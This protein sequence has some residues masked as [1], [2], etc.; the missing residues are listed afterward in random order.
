[1]GDSNYTILLVEDDENDAMLVR[2][3]F[4]KNNI[5]NP[6]QWAK[7]GLEAVAYLNGNGV[8]ADRQAYPFPDVLIVDLKMPRMNGLELLAWIRDH[9][10]YRVI[11]TIIITSSR[12]DVDIEK[13]Y[14]LGANTYMIKPPALDEL[15]K[16]VKV[17]HEYWSASAKPKSKFHKNAL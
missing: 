12:L 1:M 17:A 13:A 10:E 8:Y 7:D 11:P 4:Q 2:L 16:M 3:A 14:G 6:I 5:L 15:V 9:P